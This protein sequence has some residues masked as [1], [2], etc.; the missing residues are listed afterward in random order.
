MP[1]GKLT[2]TSEFEITINFT[3][4]S[5]F[6]YLTFLSPISSRSQSVPGHDMARSLCLLVSSLLLQTTGLHLPRDTGREVR[7][8]GL[9][10]LLRSRFCADGWIL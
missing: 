10:R 8:G 7:L 2:F 4:S 3:I 9:V 6:Y 5:L 1:D